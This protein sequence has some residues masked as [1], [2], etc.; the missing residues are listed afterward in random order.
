MIAFL[1]LL[2]FFL[3]P[4]DSCIWRTDML[5]NVWKVYGN[6]GKLK[7]ER[8]QHVI[9][10]YFLHWV[11]HKNLVPS[12][13]FAQSRRIRNT[14]E[15]FLRIPVRRRRRLLL[16]SSSLSA[17][18]GVIWKRCESIPPLSG[19]SYLWCRLGRF[20]CLCPCATKEFNDKVA[21]SRSC[22]FSV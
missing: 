14:L 9:C 18:D 15:A 19:E 8:K 6:L 2:S 17:D 10:S 13:A 20:M 7:K 4:C 1:I 12:C 21:L 22:L 5:L 16:S 11:R 3:P